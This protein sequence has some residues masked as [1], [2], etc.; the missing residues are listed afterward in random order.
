MELNER[1]QAQLEKLLKQLPLNS[2]KRLM[3]IPGIFYGGGCSYMACRGLMMSPI[4]DVLLITHGPTGCGFFSGINS[5]NDINEDGKELFRG[6]SFSTNMRE[7]DIIFGG[8]QKL[9]TAIGEAVR[10]FKPKAVA[11]CATCPVGLIGDDIEQ[12]AKTAEERYGIRV[13]PLSCEG[14]ALSPP[15]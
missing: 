3:E 2:E 4:D 15:T 1:R 11:V 8:E 5:R 7:Q 13:L 9:L 12:I 10:L 6:R 14:L